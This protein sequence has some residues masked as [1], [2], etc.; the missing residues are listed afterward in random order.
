MSKHLNPTDVQILRYLAEC[1]CNTPSGFAD[2]I[3]LHK[4]NV[5]NRLGRLREKFEPPAVE[6]QG[7]GC[8]H[9]TEAGR[10]LLE[11]ELED[12]ETV[13]HLELRREDL[14]SDGELTERGREWLEALEDAAE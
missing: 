5:S 9:L 11:A 2:D 4:K 10:E 13:L 14:V 6:V 8:Y 7:T 12:D 3:D 1:G